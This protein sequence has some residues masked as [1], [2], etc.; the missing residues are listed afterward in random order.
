[1]DRFI[2]LKVLVGVIRL[3]SSYSVC[4]SGKLEASQGEADLVNSNVPSRKLLEGY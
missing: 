1:M 3:L 4:Y 2:Y